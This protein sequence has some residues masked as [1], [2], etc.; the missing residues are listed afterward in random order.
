M[1]DMETKS[2]KLETNWKRTVKTGNE[3]ETKSRMQEMTGKERP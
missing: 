3:V 2:S 1:G